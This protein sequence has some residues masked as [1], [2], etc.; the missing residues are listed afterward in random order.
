MS[1]GRSHWVMDYETMINCFVGVFEH[2]KKDLLKVFVVTELRN[3]FVQF[4]DFLLENKKNREWHVSFN[5]ISFDSQ[6]TEF[7][8]RNCDRL[9]KLSAA[10]IAYEIY[11]Q[12]Q[13][14]IDLS[15]RKQRAEFPEWKLSIQQV[16]VFKMNHWDNANKSSSLKWVEFSMDW[17]NV[18]DMPIHHATPVYTQE[19]LDM[20]IGY[21][22]NDVKA[23]KQAMYYSKPLVNVR[24]MIKAKYGLP[25]YSYSNTKLGSELLLKLYC[26]A[27]NRDPWEVKKYRTN[28]NGIPI[29]DILFNYVEFKSKEFKD[30]HELLLTKTI[31]NTKNDF[32]YQQKFKGYTFY[33]GAGGIHQC[34][35]TGIY[36][37][38]DR[39]IIKDLDVAS[40]YPSI[41]CVNE[42]YPAHLGKEFFNVYK[43]NI[44]DVRLAEKAKPKADRDMAIIEGFKEAANATYGNS[45]SE[46]SW[47]Y[48]P[49]YTM[50]TTINGQLLITML[51][52]ELLMS[53]PESKL[54]QT[55][56]DGA[57][58]YFPKEY[59]ELYDSICKAWEEK[60]KL[61]LEFADYASMYI[62]DVNNY[63]A[64]YT[65]SKS[66]CKGRFEWEDQQNHKYTHLHK[67]K[68]YLIVSKAIF[69]YFVNDIPPERYLAENRNIY[70]YCAGVKIKG[71][72]WQFIETCVTDQ[73]LKQTVLQ[74]TLRYYISKGG[75]KIVKV[76]KSDGREIQV[77]AGK[78]MQTN[79][80]K[81]EE[82][83]WEDY[84]VNDDY[85]LEQIYKEIHN[86]C[87]P[88]TNQLELN[89]P[90]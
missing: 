27:T 71:D 73:E 46:Y 1:E 3:D 8:I 28:R 80:S 23:T 32:K 18:Q 69:N 13:K 61:T 4:V 52:E 6:I 40:L 19:D 38:D 17:P 2:Y 15:K 37:A 48:D 47:L 33:Y 12:A 82:K 78:W 9:L 79:F 63:F 67:N 10:E 74:K 50:Q 29:K 11:K 22:G 70:D 39:F 44:V 64:I 42:M 56:T 83:T 53:I 34:I 51:V 45:N 86:I 14:T 57:T 85:Y 43:H 65:D 25:C 16:D 87:P 60:T 84:D 75:C 5:G 35:E 30:F 89:F 41:A 20:I 26:N 90:I 31:W 59:L 88:I 81:Y 58:L 62:W 54:L 55:N 7:V 72:D 21:C 68:S 66:K 36:K 24:V 77:E 49:Q 76:N